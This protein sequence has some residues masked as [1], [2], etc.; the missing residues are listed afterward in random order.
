MIHNFF[1]Q[2]HFTCFTSFFLMG[3][4]QSTSS[5]T[6]ID[7]GY[8]LG[9]LKPRYADNPIRSNRE[10]L[11]NWIVDEIVIVL[12]PLSKFSNL[13]TKPVKCVSWILPSK[14]SAAVFQHASIVVLNRNNPNDG[15]LVE[16][17]GYDYRREGDYFT[18]VHYFKG[19][20]GLRFTKMP[21]G[22]IYRFFGD[23]C[24]FIPC[25]V[26]KYMTL[27]DLCERTMTQ[28][29]A[30]NFH[31]WSKENYNLLGQNCQLWARKAIQVLEAQRI[32]ELQQVR[33]VSKTIIPDRILDALEE[34]EKN[35]LNTVEKIPIIGQ[36]FGLGRFYGTFIAEKLVDLLDL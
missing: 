14:I 12:S 9:I 27:Y 21:I 26:N 17:G 32:S 8:D 23:G 6:S 3:S 5:S 19:V 22:S 28:S 2:F 33:T 13:A 29:H 4:G 1:P 7:I 34:N 11:L 36:F 35:P 15:I 16:Y 31:N 25:H 10:E 24:A 20:N 30:G 18:E